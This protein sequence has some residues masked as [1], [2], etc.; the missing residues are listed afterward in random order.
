MSTANRTLFSTP[1]HMHILLLRHNQLYVGQLL[2]QTATPRSVR[3]SNHRILGAVKVDAVALERDMPFPL[4][5]FQHPHALSPL[6]EFRLSFLP[7]I[8]I[9]SPKYSLHH[10]PSKIPEHAYAHDQDLCAAAAGFSW[11]QSQVQRH[12]SMR[13]TVTPDIKKFISSTDDSKLP[14]PPLH[15]AA[16]VAHHRTVVRLSLGQA[17]S[18]R[19]QIIGVAGA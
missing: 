9:R 1:Q 14:E 8:E 4:G 13:S 2:C 11:L 17:P 6:P 16:G 18:I 3:L 12:S 19:R 7:A 15:L 5:P 10:H